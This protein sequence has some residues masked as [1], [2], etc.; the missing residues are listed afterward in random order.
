MVT[1]CYIS[2]NKH[3]FFYPS[4]ET[5]ESV[6]R[7]QLLFEHRVINLYSCYVAPNKVNTNKK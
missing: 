4:Q 7:S 6:K 3:T 1:K 2:S 5:G